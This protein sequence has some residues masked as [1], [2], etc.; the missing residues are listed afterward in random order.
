MAGELAQRL[1]QIVLVP[2]KFARWIAKAPVMIGQPVTQA[3]VVESS[4]ENFI[5]KG[6]RR[7]AG[8]L[9][10]KLRYFVLV[11]PTS[12]PRWIAKAPMMIG[13]PVAQAV[14]VES[15]PENFMSRGSRCM[16]CGRTFLRH[17][18]PPGGSRK[19]LS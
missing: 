10:Q 12:A 18:S 11:V 3:V 15:N 13:Q 2:P 17:P 5:S 8:E 4:P 9:A 14:V 16:A 1:W 6:S 7:M 19:R